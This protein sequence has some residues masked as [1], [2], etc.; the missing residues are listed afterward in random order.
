MV[1]FINMFIA[2]L[3]LAAAVTGFDVG[4][5]RGKVVSDCQNFGAFVY[6]GQ[7]YVCS[8]NREAK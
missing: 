1:S 6:K 7:R 4:W 2:V 3:V 5:G 8:A